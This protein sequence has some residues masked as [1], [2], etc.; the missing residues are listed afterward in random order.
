VTFF[1]RT[2]S[3]GKS[4]LLFQVKSL[5]IYDSLHYQEPSLAD[6][7]AGLAL[8]LQYGTMRLPNDR[9]S[10]TKQRR[11]K[12]MITAM[13]KMP[14]HTNSLREALHTDDPPFPLL[15]TVAM[16]GHGDSS[17]GRL[18][19]DAKSAMTLPTERIALSLLSLP[20][21]EH[22]CQSVALGPLAVPPEIF[23]PLHPPKIVTFHYAFAEIDVD[24]TPMQAPIILGATNRLI[25]C[26]PMR[27]GTEEPITHKHINNTSANL[28]QFL[29]AFLSRK[30][31]IVEVNDES[32]ED[33]ATTSSNMRVVDFDKVSLDGT[34][35][36]VYNQV[37]NVKVNGTEP[38]PRDDPGWPWSRK[39][40]EAM[41]KLGDTLWGR[42]KGRVKIRN[43]EDIPACPS[44]G[45]DGHRP[46][47]VKL[48][49]MDVKPQLACRTGLTVV[50]Y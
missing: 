39:T 41:E 50:S 30:S 40:C 18:K 1:D 3:P 34:F 26:A 33:P 45:F 32:Q 27:V 42:W 8:W 31:V 15:K 2:T 37:R 13:I 17:F 25:Y 4:D 35:I 44:C 24:D 6:L 22:Y 16:G 10:G 36:E 7:F 46:E 5:R 48:L 49:W 21:V 19:G 9:E 29:I 20:S 43:R 38:A 47:S 23:K 11:G 12:S 14:Y 28:I